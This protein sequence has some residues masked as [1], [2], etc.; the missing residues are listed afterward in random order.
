VYD[1]TSYSAGRKKVL[2]SFLDRENIFCSIELKNRIVERRAKENISNLI[3]L[4]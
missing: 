1:N 4:L 2:K 3:P